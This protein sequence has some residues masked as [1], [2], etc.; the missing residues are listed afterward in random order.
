[1]I[2]PFGSYGYSKEDKIKAYVQ[3]YDRKMWMV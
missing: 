1:M 3:K 2:C